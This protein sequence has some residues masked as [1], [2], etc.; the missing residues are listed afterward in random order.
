ML[1]NMKIGTRLSLGFDIVLALL[2]V[3]GGVGK[4]GMT[5]LSNAISTTLKGNVAVME[6]ASRARANALGLRRFEK[7]YQ[8]IQAGEIKTTQEGN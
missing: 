2:L 7:F 1:S 4:W 3:L 6:Q 8:K 5:S